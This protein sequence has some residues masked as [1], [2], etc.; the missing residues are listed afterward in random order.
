M[1]N[2]FEII[3]NNLDQLN[4][5]LLSLEPYSKIHLPDKPKSYPNLDLAKYIQNT[6]LGITFSVINH[7]H[8]GNLVKI[9][10]DLDQ[11][12]LHIK[13][14]PNLN[15]LLIVSGSKPKK[16]NTLN[17][18]NYLQTKT[19]A[20]GNGIV[21]NPKITT[22]ELLISVA[23]NCQS[24][25]Q[26]LENERFKSK[27]ATKIVK[28][29]YIQI[30]D[31]LQKIQEAIKFIRNLKPDV[32]ISVCVFQPSKSSLI[33]FKFRPWKGVALSDKFLESPESAKQINTHNLEI[34]KTLNV[35]FIF[36]I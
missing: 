30:T 13:N 3:L 12:L 8:G 33:K 26:N 29:I 15:E 28:K 4:L 9:I 16:I 21:F 31:N 7:Y 14:Q 17:I 2:T 19:L 18:L 24:P 25:N 20:D 5:K 32:I 34:L 1:N 35:E 36:T 27:L 11:Y 6:E 22:K 23:Y 10:A